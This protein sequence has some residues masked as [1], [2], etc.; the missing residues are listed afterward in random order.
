MVGDIQWLVHIQMPGICTMPVRGTVEPGMGHK[1]HITGII[2]FI[3][4]GL[5]PTSDLLF[6]IAV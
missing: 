5:N 1:T 3:Q 4:I 2:T 6:N